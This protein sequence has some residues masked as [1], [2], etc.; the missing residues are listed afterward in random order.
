MYAKSKQKVLDFLFVE[1]LTQLK[2]PPLCILTFSFTRF[3]S[4]LETFIY[5]TCLFLYLS[6]MI[7]YCTEK[8]GIEILRWYLYL[9][10]LYIN[11]H[12]LHDV[13][14]FIEKC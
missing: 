13:L 8:K 11:I 7:F 9:L 14:V 4:D 2:N 3:G 1:S 12:L 5:V 10:Y 6:Y